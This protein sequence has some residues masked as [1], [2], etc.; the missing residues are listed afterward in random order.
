M[1]SALLDF[2]LIGGQSKHAPITEGVANQF[3]GIH[4]LRIGRAAGSVSYLLGRITVENQSAARAHGLTQRFKLANSC[5]RSH[6]LNEDCNDE[7][8]GL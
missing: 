3:G 2:T 5:L 6:K 8:E 4:I 7:I 1:A